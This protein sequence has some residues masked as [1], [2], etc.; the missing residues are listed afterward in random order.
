MREI[1]FPRNTKSKKILFK[2]S[3]HILTTIIIY[4]TLDRLTP[5]LLSQFPKFLE[6]FKD[7]NLIFQEMDPSKYI[8]IIDKVQNIIFTS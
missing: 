2:F 5:F 7:M 8:E 4:Q 6:F 3:I 1:P